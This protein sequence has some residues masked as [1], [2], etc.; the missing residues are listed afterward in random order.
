V[1]IRVFDP[2]QNRTLD[3]LSELSTVVED[4]WDFDVAI[5]RSK[6][7]VTKDFIDK[8]K[9]LKL[10]LRAGVG[11]DNIDLNY[12]KRREIK[13]RSTAGASSTSVAELVFAHL[14]SIARKTVKSTEKMKTGR[15]MKE[16]GIELT[17]KTMGIVG[18]GRIG[19]EVARRA[20]A[21]RMKVVTCD[22]FVTGS[23]FPH[24]RLNEL[25]HISDIITLH[26]PLNERTRNM[27]NEEAIQEM[28]D[29]VI[30]INTSRG[31]IIDENALY[32]ALMKGKVSYAGL[33]VFQNEPTPSKKL[34]ELNNV[35]LTSHIGG[36]TFDAQKRIGDA[37]IEEV[38][39]YIKKTALTD[40]DLYVIII[41]SE[42]RPGIT[43]ALTSILSKYKVPILDAEQATLQGLLA[44]SFLVQI[45]KPVK[46]KV[47]RELLAVAK[48]IDLNIKIRPHKQT[49]KRRDKKLYALTCLSNAPR[50]EVLT[51]V[52][53]ILSQN[54]ANIE[55]IRQF[56]G[57]D[58]VALELLIDI[59]NT[60]DLEKLKQEIMGAAEV[61]NFDVALQKENVFRKSKRLIVFNTVTTLIDT[62]IIEEIAKVAG[63][64]R[65]LSTLTKAA[66][67]DEDKFKASI[68][69]R[70]AILKGVSLD[71]LKYVASNLRWTMG[72]RELIDMLKQMAFKIALISG[73]LTY[74][75]DIL[76][77]ELGLDYAFSNRLVIKDKQLTGELEE[78]IIEGSE[79]TAILT[80]IA[81][82]E[83]IPL[84]QV[85]AVGHGINDA[86]LL[87]KAGLGIAF[88]PTGDYK[89]FV[90][91]TIQ[92]KNLKSILYMLGLSVE[93]NNS[94]Y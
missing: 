94:F 93:N 67:K 68:Q 45:K 35:V 48:K 47:K 24:L 27:I 33:D 30:I 83:G 71:A 16:A 32:E 11:L 4:G 78:P 1:K 39:D 42:D 37:V 90:K 12:C 5:V 57:K 18:F 61:L 84:D 73:S 89:K 22:P 19:R 75:T 17:E 40:P 60:E 28:K 3:Q 26:L 6:T 52:S 86:E 25:F 63:V 29:G 38:K 74:F 9:N 13:V 92:Q 54:N 31:E 34:L 55:T 51:R 85:V 14:L 10:V 2:L 80:Q 46:E 88:H 7:E 82:K 58:L 81:E 76:K 15:W 50:G 77:E 23:E 53:S 70:V 44:L 72:A 21:F 69:E 79:K 20:K 59:S 64:Q 56:H 36:N 49:R 65:E 62:D 91:G 66:L 8:A 43:A 41:S 87:S